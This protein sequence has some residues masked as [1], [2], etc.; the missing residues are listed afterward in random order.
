TPP[1][2]LFDT[3][4]SPQFYSTGESA[5]IIADIENVGGSRL[6]LN[7]NTVLRLQDTQNAN[8]N[9]SIPI[10]LVTSDL[11]LNPG[12][13]VRIESQDSTL[14]IPGTFRLFVDI[15]GTA[16]GAD[17]SQEVNSS[18]NINVGGDIFVSQLTVSPN[19]VAPGATGIEI[20]VQVQNNTLPATVE[21]ST[22]TLNYADNNEPLLV[23]ATLI[24]SVTIIPQTPGFGLFRWRFDLPIVRTGPVRASV[25]FS[26]NGGA[27]QLNYSDP[28]TS[29]NI[30]SG[31]DIAFVDGSLQPNSVVN[32]EFVSFSAQFSNSGNTTLLV[33]PATS[34]ITFND[35]GLTY[36]ALV[37]G[38]FT[39]RGTQ[40][41]TPDT[42]T[43]NF[44][45]V[46]LDDNF[47]S[48]LYNVTYS[49]QGGLPNGDS[50]EGYDT[51]TTSPILTV[52]P[53][54]DVV[55]AGI[56]ILPTDI[57]RGQTGVQI[58]YT[59]RNDGG[60]AASISALNGLF[61][62]TSGNDITFS[63]Q[64]TAISPTLPVEIVP[65]GTATITRDYTVLGSAPLGD[66]TAFVSGTFNDVRKPLQPGSYEDLTTGDV[67]NVTTKAGLNFTGVLGS[68][69][70]ALDGTVSTFQKFDWSLT[71]NRVSG[72]GD[73]VPNDPTRIE[74]N[75][76]NRGFFF[77]SLLTIDSDTVTI[78][79]DQTVDVEIWAGSDPRLATLRAVVI[80]TS[81]DASSG[82]PAVLNTQ[83]L[84][85]SMLIQNRANLTLDIQAP[86]LVDTS[87]FT[88]TAVVENIGTAGIVP[89][90]VSVVLDTTRLNG[91]LLTS[92]LNF[93]VPLN[94]NNGM[95][96][97]A[98]LTFDG[99]FEST[100]DSL[101]ASISTD[102]AQDSNAT[103]I[104]FKSIQNDTAVVSVINQV[105]AISNERI[106]NPPGATDGV[107]STNQEFLVKADYLFNATVVD[108]NTISSFITVPNGYNG[109][110]DTLETPLPSSSGSIEWSV[111]APA[112]AAPLQ[113][114]TLT[115]TGNRLS[116]SELIE[117]TR[118]VPVKT[119]RRA[120]L[121][122][123]GT[124]IEPSG[125]L[126]G[127][128]STNQF[129]DI[130]IAIP[131]S[132]EAGTVDGFDNRVRTVLPTG[133]TFAEQRTDT[134]LFIATDG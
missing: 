86:S 14:T 37:D 34:S 108:T 92:P 124:I 125:A 95:R 35:G 90:S 75:L 133:Y 100:N 53:D 28:G 119:V 109:G 111:I 9:I 49:M 19:E 127:V 15:N 63:F 2:I 66:V 38:N 84:T 83:T 39:I 89:N 6:V 94:Q 29:F 18:T 7:G 61:A 72:T 65:G 16:F 71:V 54:A 43:L 88:M 99:L 101:L 96:G 97:E 3:L 51:T 128:L 112:I 10:D 68:P 87:N 47:N 24:D 32:G 45:N 5:R 107:V 116:G 64:T 134:T 31:I 17:F 74:L 98:L 93:T 52:L 78:I 11:T 115:F 80:D 114:I 118:Q 23:T 27:E 36:Q 126:D 30:I 33:D 73:L 122:V 123:V 60:S 46:Q 131:D 13:T 77:D 67:V 8:Q 57:N 106:S 59:L 130:R 26:L 110:N 25:S 102:V 121:S 21:S 62:D 103:Q 129:F 55:V 82:E 48:G 113:N 132:G 12:E 81:R 41:A 44:T 56:D 117:I 1:S 76:E 79:P 4:Q 85:Q 91:V 120:E 58:Q 70:G 42:S 22:L 69:A 104:A 105:A 50:F 20:A 40:D